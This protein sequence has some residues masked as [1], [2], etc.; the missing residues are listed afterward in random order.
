M[1]SRRRRSLHLEEAAR[2][3][4]GTRTGNRCIRGVVLRQLSV[5]RFGYVHHRQAPAYMLR[6]G[7]AAA[8]PDGFQMVP[9]LGGNLNWDGAR[10]R[11]DRC[12]AA[13]LIP[14]LGLARRLARLEEA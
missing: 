14:P 2:N 13:P 10:Y 1:G 4:G 5:R 3:G 6:P 11:V 12:L 7:R 9:Y 8:R